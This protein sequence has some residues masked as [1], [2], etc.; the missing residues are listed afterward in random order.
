MGDSRIYLKSEAELTLMRRSGQISAKALKTVLEAAKPGITLRELDK[1][2]EEVITKAGAEPGFK[3]VS[4][5]NFTTCLNINNELVHGLPRD[6]KLRQGDKL[7][8]DLGACLEGWNTDTAWSIIVGEEPN[9]FLKVGEKALWSAID[10]VKEGR[11]LGDIGHTIQSIIEGAH[12]SISHTLIGHGVG[13]SLHE[14]PEVPGFGEPNS[15]LVLKAGMTI[16]IEIIY[17]AGSAEGVVGPD[18]WTVMT[19]DGSLGGLFE[20]TVIVKTDG[21]EVITDWRSA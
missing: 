6:I 12:F 9:F 3:K 7:S 15:G 14:A 17:A 20:M 8:V 5:Y 4:G 1:I 21:Y 11:H 18:N 19:A 2:A 13:K 10:L 16:A